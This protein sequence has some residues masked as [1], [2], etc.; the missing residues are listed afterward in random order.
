MFK[1]YKSKP[2]ER[3]ALRLDFSI[4]KLTEIDKNTFTL[5][6]EG[7]FVCD[8]KAYQEVEDGDYVCYLNGND[9]YHC[10]AKIFAEQNEVD[11]NNKEC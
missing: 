10:C 6:R 4:D 2:I 1:S 8:F 9:I 3:L 7:E 5:R 11:N